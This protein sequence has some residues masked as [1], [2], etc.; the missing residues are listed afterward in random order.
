MRISLGYPDAAP[1]RELLAGDDRREMLKD[2]PSRIDA[3]TLLAWQAQVDQVHVA[4]AL[5]DYV[6][7]LLDATRNSPRWEMGLSP[8]AGLALLRAARAWAMIDGRGQVVPEDVQAVLPSVAGHRLQRLDGDEWPP[9]LRGLIEAV[10][11]SMENRLPRAHG[12]CQLGDTDRTSGRRLGHGHAEVGAPRIYILPTR[13][14]FIFAVLVFL[15][16]LGAVNYGNNP[17]HLLTFLLA[18]LGSNAIYLTWRNLRGLKLR[19]LGCAPV[20][21]G[22]PR[23]CSNCRATGT[24]A[25][26]YSWDSTAANRCSSTCLPAV[27]P[28]AGNCAWARTR[29]AN[30]HPVDWSS[31]PG[32][33]SGC[34]APG[35]MSTATGRCWSTRSRAPPGRPGATLPTRPKTAAGSGSED[36]VGLRAY[37]AGDQPSRIDWKS[38]ARDRGLNTRLFSGLAETPVWFDWGD[39]PGA[40][41]E[42]RLSAMCRAV[43]DAEA[44]RSRVWPGNASAD[45]RAWR[46][47]GAP[48]PMPATSRAAR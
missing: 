34:S 12:V 7:S 25:P 4:P 46:R 20:F 2:V 36:F 1:E 39:A 24:S 29:V 37:V 6:Q 11:H 23:F 17:A 33:R 15:M 10:R 19:C 35:A 43:I 47:S 31:V 32:T 38:Y 30:I 44:A 26:R 16:L 28:C 9:R 22:Q 41:T 48:S 13:Y 5:L 18:A 8:R 42:S 40:D 14:G 45:D 27:T 21:A 3:D